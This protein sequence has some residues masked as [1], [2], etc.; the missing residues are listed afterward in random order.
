MKNDNSMY[1]FIDTISEP[2]YLALF[3]E[4]RDIISEYRW[5]AKQKEFDTLVEAIDVFLK[6]NNASYKTLSAIVVVV[7]PAGFTGTRVTTL[8]AN[9][10]GYGFHTPLFAIT[11]GEMFSLQDTP[12][13]WIT[14]V[15]KKE[16]LIWDN[17]NAQHFNIVPIAELPE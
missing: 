10:I 2:G 12:M 1:L 7:G 13:P 5:Q 3:D 9:T 8:V 6:N 4:K 16:V 11:V 17:D 14:P 15:T